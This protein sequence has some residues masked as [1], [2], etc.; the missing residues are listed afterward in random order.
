MAFESVGKI[1]DRVMANAP[2]PAD[3][4][5]LTPQARAE[6]E[7][8]DETRRANGRDKSG[9]WKTPPR[10]I[11][12]PETLP[13]HSYTETGAWIYCP[14]KSQGYCFLS[15]NEYEVI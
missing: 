10:G 5:R 11:A 15:R 6:F 12:D 4:V 14:A 7:A 3:C 8:D 13:V 2:A 9:Q 1:L